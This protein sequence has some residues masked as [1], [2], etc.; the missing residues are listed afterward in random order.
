MTLSTQE[1]ERVEWLLGKS[2]VAG[3]EPSEENELRVLITK[4]NP[5]ASNLP[6]KDLIETGLVFVGM[7]LLVSRLDAKALWNEA[8]K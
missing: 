3:I 6:K 7:S 2:L 4:E 8:G 5:S 1:F